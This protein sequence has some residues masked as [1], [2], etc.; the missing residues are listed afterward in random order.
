MVARFTTTPVLPPTNL[1]VV[2]PALARKQIR[3]K[4]RTF[5]S[6]Y[7]S[8]RGT[9]SGREREGAGQASV[10]MRTCPGKG[11]GPPTISRLSTV[12][13]W[14]AL[15]AD[16]LA[17]RWSAPRGA[18]RTRQPGFR[19]PVR[20]GDRSSLDPRTARCV[21]RGRSTALRFLPACGLT[22]TLILPLLCASSFLLQS[23]GTRHGR[24]C[25]EPGPPQVLTRPELPTIKFPVEPSA[26]L[27][28]KQATVRV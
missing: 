25:R 19:A 7:P 24:V 12:S 10:L 26:A 3:Q 28:L 8:G 6:G 21:S 5:S 17:G 23:P 15:G 9:G 20:T 11:L 1:V 4:V 22:L 18:P 2:N 13:T 14:R 16:S 27:E